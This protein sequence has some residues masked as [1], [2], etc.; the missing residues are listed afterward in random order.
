MRA[1]Y[2]L[3]CWWDVSNNCFV[4]RSPDYEV[5]WGKGSTHA[6]AV[7]ALDDQ[8]QEWI[9]T[10][11]ELGVDVSYALPATQEQPRPVLEMP[12]PSQKDIPKKPKQKP[13]QTTRSSPL[14]A[15][16]EALAAAQEASINAF[17]L[18]FTV[19]LNPCIIHV[20]GEMAFLTVQGA[21][22]EILRLASHHSNI[23]FDL[24]KVSY[25]DS[26]GMTLLLESLKRMTFPNASLCIV[27]SGV[28][29]DQVERIFRLTRFD[30]IMPVFSSLEEAIA[31]SQESKAA[32]S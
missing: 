20:R 10:G 27:V 7:A 6:E 29:G 13:K 16:R 1:N 26:T 9:R 5:C 23:I 25:I 12:A 22:D 31:I 4:A 11:R 8:V 3:C 21:R 17:P 14:K 15:L 32:A 2:G 28:K 30:T 19:T 18:D 24:S